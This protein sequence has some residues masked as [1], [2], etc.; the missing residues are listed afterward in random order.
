MIYLFVV[1]SV[2]K[3]PAG[4]EIKTN[5]RTLFFFVFEEKKSCREMKRKKNI[6]PTR[7]LEKKKLADQKSSPPLKS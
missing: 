3:A 2:N 6:L 4:I 7:L 5:V 1:L